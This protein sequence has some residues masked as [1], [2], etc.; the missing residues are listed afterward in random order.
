[1]PYRILSS[2][3]AS[4]YPKWEYQ[5]L[6]SFGRVFHAHSTVYA[7]EDDLDKF[8]MIKIYVVNISLD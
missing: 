7:S 4:D 2:R 1:M 5:M 6:A 3:K 8:E